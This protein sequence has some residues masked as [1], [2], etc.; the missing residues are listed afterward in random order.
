MQT[1]FARRVGTLASLGAAFSILWIGGGLGLAAAQSAPPAAAPGTDEATEPDPQAAEDAALSP[2]GDADEVDY[3]LPSD[4]EGEVIVITGSR[5]RHSSLVAPVPVTTLDSD[6]IVLSGKTDMVDVVQRV[7]GLL[8]SINTAQTADQ[9]GIE[10]DSDLGSNVG[11]ATLNLRGLGTKRTLVLVD[12]RRHVGGRPGDTAVD[13]NTIP[14]ALIERVEILTGGASAIYGADAVTGVVNFITKRDLDGFEGRTQVDLNDQGDGARYFLSAASGT[15]LADGRGHATV[16]LEYRRQ[17]KYLCGDADFCRGFGVLDDDGNPDGGDDDPPRIFRR[18]RTFAISSAMGRIGIDFDGDGN[19]D[20]E[21]PDGFFLDTN[22]DNVN[23]VGQTF[24]GAEGFGDWVVDSGDLRLFNA[25]EIASFANQFGGDGIASGPFDFQ[26]LLPEQDSVVANALLRYELVPDVNFFTDMKFVYGKTVQR[27]QVNGFNDLLTVTLEN[28][29]VPQAMRA[30]IDQAVLTNPALADTTTIYIT[31]DFLDLGENITENEHQT[32]R[33]VTGF[34]GQIGDGIDY[35][36]SF[37]YGRTSEELL[38]RGTR[39]EDR[40]FAAIDVVSDADGNPICRSELDPSAPPPPTSPFPAV[41]PGF[42]TFVPGDGSC[43]PL[44]LFGYGAPSQEAID[45]VTADVVQTATIEQSVASLSF[46]G[47]TASS[48]F[49]LPAGPIG[50]ASGGEYRRE[51]S[52]YRPDQ[53][54]ETGLAFDGTKTV[55]VEGQ[56]DVWEVFSELSVPILRRLPGARDLSIDAALR[57][58]NYSTVGSSVSWKVRANWTPIS[59][60]RLRGGYSVAVR[61]PNVGELFQAETAAFFRPIDPCDAEQIPTAPDPEVRAR[62][63]SDDG[64]PDD[65][66]DPLTGRFAGVQA[67]NPDLDEERANTYN[68]GAVVTPSF[69]GGLILSFDYFNIELVDAI[70]NISSQDIV[71]N[72]YDDPSGIDNQFCDLFTRNRDL[73]SPTALGLNFMRVG[74]LNI[75]Q[76]SVSG[77]DFEATYAFGLERVGAPEWGKL[78]WRFYGTWLRKLDELPNQDDDSFVNPELR[79]I[80]R[81]AVVLNSGLRWT[82]DRLSVNYGL[83]FM[84]DQAYDDVEIESAEETFVNP[85][86]GTVFI[87]DLSARYAVLDDLSVYGGVNNLADRDPLGTSTSFPVSP[88]GRVFFLGVSSRL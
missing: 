44:N 28:P 65:Y 67:G 43:K 25:G 52:R 5:I 30:A 47:D 35:E 53:L 61:A 50:Y 40:F 66:T 23:D 73:G 60:V 18:H 32:M 75:G 74:Q 12:G 42:R 16:A 54:S 31:R 41:E 8:T 11:V 13:V 7:P 14:A 24:L 10:G 64:L 72:C 6:D 3:E 33:F 62:N 70:E 37:N 84:S 68:I 39:I 58:A 29:Y 36:L 81:P 59:D 22:G 85:Y 57:A 21:A 38:L 83:T 79:E 77:I 76:K 55:G 2:E 19:P 34:E 87:H 56:Y 4:G 80:R 63:C 82:W 51:F 20:S 69:I 78:D 49:T 26:T 46:S 88:L 27:G 9:Q 15:E 71:N 48:G 86:A 17:S 45:F 1:H